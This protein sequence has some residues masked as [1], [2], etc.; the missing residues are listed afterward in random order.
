MVKI[1]PYQLLRGAK[2]KIRINSYCYLRQPTLS[3]IADLS[4][5]K[6]QEFLTTFLVKKS[7]LLKS[8]GT[9]DGP[10]FDQYS[11]YD[12]MLLIPE[13]RANLLDAL[14]F[15]VCGSVTADELT[16]YVDGQPLSTQDLHD[17]AA[18]V[19]KISYIESDDESQHVFASEKSR[20]LWEKMQKGRQELKKAKNGDS[21][22]EL[23]NLIS[24]LAARGTG[25]NLFNIWDLTVYQLYDQFARTNVNVQMDIYGSRWAAWGKDDFDV[26]MWYH[27][28][29]QK[30]G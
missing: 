13:L 25:Y 26:S 30:E 8:L 24:A 10:E 1:S 2:A 11:I 18:A 21:N 28:L 15:F 4:Y 9:E 20:R 17:I 23:T 16:V 22:M 14:A 6:Y 19:A 12:I 7:D 3:N 5:D 29:T 27:N